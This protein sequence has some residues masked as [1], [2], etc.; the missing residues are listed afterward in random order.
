LFAAA[1]AGG[2]VGMTRQ[3]TNRREGEARGNDLFLLYEVQRRL[4]VRKSLT[5]F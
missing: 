1:L 3:G 4:E 2:A 5:I